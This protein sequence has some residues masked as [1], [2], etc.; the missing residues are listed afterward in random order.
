MSVSAA[1]GASL[2]D[3]ARPP[4]DSFREPAPPP[5]VAGPL[6][7]T[8]LLRPDLTPAPWRGA[9]VH[10]GFPTDHP[11]V[12]RFWTA[13]IG[14][15]AVA[16]LMRLA[17]AAQRGRSLPRPES[18]GILVREDL[19]RWADGRLYVRTAIPRLSPIQERRLTPELRRQHRAV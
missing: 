10:H 13:A 7:P 4:T 2:T 19:A 9:G 6:R 17:V 15:G 18:I 1:S 8:A 11:Y 14:P 16:D 3:G 5:G 12:R